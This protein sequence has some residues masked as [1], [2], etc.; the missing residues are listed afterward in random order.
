V[1]ARAPLEL[2]RAGLG[3]LLATYTAPADWL[4]ARL[5]GQDDSYS[6]VAVDLARAHVDNVLQ[7]AEG[8]HRRDPE[9]LAELAAALTLS[10]ISMGVAGRTAPGSGMEHTVSH[11][12][13]MATPPGQPG[14]LH[15]AMVG[16]LSPLAA[17]LWRRVRS[18]ARADGL[19]DL[20]F[21]DAA[22]LEPRVHEAFARLDPSG[23]VARECW[24]AYE[25]KLALWHDARERLAD[26]PERWP[27]FD[28]QLDE[29][30]GPPELL[31]RALREARAP[32][33]ASELAIVAEDLRWALANCQLMR[34][35]FTVAD[36]AFFMGIWE[37]ADV[38]S[39]LTD[40]ARLGAGV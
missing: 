1:I 17:L 32:V 40:P 14:P 12:I 2:N 29:L 15:G 24:R 37:P 6:A 18:V 5:V 23:A 31:V 20:R 3:D 33:R 34:D 30:L 13:E 27:E 38:E 21:P 7:N 11:L 9:V 28:A 36:L 26:L 16:A 19:R 10:G 4:L 22:E 35:R 8:I 25:R 39:L